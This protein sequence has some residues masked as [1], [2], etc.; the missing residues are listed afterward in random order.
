MKLTAKNVSAV[1]VGCMWS[2]EECAKC[3]REEMEAKSKLVEGI[4]HVA[5]FKPTKLE[6]HKQQI[7]SML[8]QLLPSF[9][10]GDSFHKGR[11]TKHG[12]EWGSPLDVEHLFML[13]M[14]INKVL[15]L[16]PREMWKMLP[17]SLPVYQ[18]LMGDDDSRKLL[19]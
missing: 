16:Y 11:Y 13:G 2:D 19:N 17:H 4:L 6:E 18:V 5:G 10:H 8:A 9:R 3:S 14:G 1:F 15:L 7:E 12:K